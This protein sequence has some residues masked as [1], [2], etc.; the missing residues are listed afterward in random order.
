MPVSPLNNQEPIKERFIR[1]VKENFPAKEAERIFRA[2]EFAEEKHRGTFRKSGEPFITHPISVS[3]ILMDFKM[4]ADTI[5]AGLLHDILEDTDTRPDEIK[6]MFG[7]NVTF[8]VEAVTK[9]QQIPIK[10]LDRDKIGKVYYQK[11]ETYR[12]M[13]LAFARD[14]RVLIIKLADRL[15]N[16]M[17]LDSLERRKREQIAR[18]TLEIYAPLAHRLGIWRIKWELEDLSFKYLEPE[19]YAE[20]ARKIKEKRRD[21]EKFLK[22]VESELSAEL[23]KRGVEAQIISRPKHIYSV[24]QKMIRKNRKFEELYDL[25]GIRI[26]TK[27]NEDVYRALGVVHSVYTPVPGRF[28][29]YVAHPKPN[30]YQSLHTT[31][32]GPDNRFIEIQIRSEIMHEIAEFGIA[33]HWRYKEEKHVDNPGYPGWL[34]NLIN[35]SRNIDDPRTYYQFLKDELR[36]EDIFVFT[37]KKDVITLKKHSTPVD[38]AYAVH[39]ELGHRT[40]AAKVNGKLVPLDYELK[41]GDVVEILTGT[42]PSPSKDWLRF[43]KTSSARQKIKA[44]FRKIERAQK[45]S[46][47][48]EEFMKLLRKILNADVDYQ[49]V[50][51]SIY[52]DL[53]LGSENNLYIQLVEG[54]INQKALRKTI[55]VKFAEDEVKGGEKIFTSIIDEFGIDEE[56]LGKI[57]LKLL[58]SF[59]M[60]A[61]EE[62]YV[63]LY[64]RRISRKKLIGKLKKFLGVQRKLTGKSKKAL[65]E[66]NGIKGLEIKFARCCIQLPGDEIVGIV[67]TSHIVTIHRKDCPNVLHYR[68]NRSRILPAY[69]ID[70]SSFSRKVKVRVVAE[71][72]TGLDKFILNTGKEKPSLFGMYRVSP[73]LKGIYGG[74]FIVD[75]T[76]NVR[77]R[78][79]LDELLGHIR[80]IK[81]VFKVRPISGAD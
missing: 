65:V 55:L 64:Q 5:I 40:R 56:N 63:A 3:M 79:E 29:D 35:T 67:T 28:K 26:I 12:K 61:E 74:K 37:P 27:N 78:S 54:R 6:D 41:N 10:G 81:G 47:G 48:K 49:E 24:Y 38:F 8:L 73:I 4:D 80:S 68:G 60:Y 18:E 32:I 19:K 25:Y 23:K 39:T 1:R 14:F 77:S 52:P 16:M 70:E 22:R 7:E 11:A 69:W 62:L 72:M 46:R 21:R 13:I 66:V 58:R 15:H 2:L 45:L 75:L 34:H 51:R 50:A 76:L 17:T 57:I 43:V 36:E 30:F 31:V 44:Y 59:N 20:L 42:T 53:R 9:I 33:A 71:D